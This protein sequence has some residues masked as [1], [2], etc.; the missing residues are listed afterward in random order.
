MAARADDAMSPGPIERHARVGAKSIAPRAR[1]EFPTSATRLELLVDRRAIPE[2]IEADDL[3][4]EVVDSPPFPYR[5]A[6]KSWVPP[7][8]LDQELRRRS[9]GSLPDKTRNKKEAQ[10]GVSR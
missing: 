1:G 4:I 6:P 3:A 9:C 7:H 10:L 2:H 8:L 5:E